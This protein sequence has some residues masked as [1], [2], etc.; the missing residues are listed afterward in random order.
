MKTVRHAGAVLG[1][2]L[3]V[4]GLAACGGSEPESGAESGSTAESAPAAAPV[5]TGPATLE[6]TPDEIGEALDALAAKVG[7]DD[8]QVTEVNVNPADITLMAVDPAAPDELNQW[9]Y[10]DGAVGESTPVDYGGDTEALKQN[11]FGLDEVDPAVVVEAIDGAPEA[12]EIED[13]V[14]ES[15]G[16]LMMPGAHEGAIIQV[17]VGGERDSKI[18]RYSLDGELVEVL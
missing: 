2:V 14:S 8:V 5:E 11:L 9:D 18:A 4:G 1:A 17:N 15:V 13:G 6:R 10:R 16:I 12:T 3:L 7:G